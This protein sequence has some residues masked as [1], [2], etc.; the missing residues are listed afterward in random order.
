MVTLKW[1]GPRPPG[2]P[3]AMDLRVIQDLLRNVDCTD[4][5]SD[6]ITHTVFLSDDHRGPAVAVWGQPSDDE[7]FH[8]EYH[9]ITQWMSL[10]DIEEY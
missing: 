9:E 8:C 5:P 1:H 3:D 4:K 10:I 6:L 2:D 7:R